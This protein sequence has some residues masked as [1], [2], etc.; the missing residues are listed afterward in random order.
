MI[1]FFVLGAARPAHQ[2]QLMQSTF[3]GKNAA[4]VMIQNPAVVSPELT[5]S[6]FVNQV[7]L[8]HRISFAPVV[9]DGFLISQID[10]DVLYAIDRDSWT[11]TRIGDFFAGLDVATVIPPDM[12]V[13]DLIA[14]TGTHRFLVVENCKLLSVVTLANLIGH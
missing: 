7:M 8:K 13:Q 9:A 5:L 11:S 2:N 6:E 10:K 1:G 14:Q 4:A 12:P 3:A